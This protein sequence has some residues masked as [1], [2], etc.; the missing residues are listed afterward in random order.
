MVTN[1]QMKWLQRK[2]T[3]KIPK[4]FLPLGGETPIATQVQLIKKLGN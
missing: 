3:K 4:I 1:R 2:I